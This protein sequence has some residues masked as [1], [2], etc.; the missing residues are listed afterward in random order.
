MIF[1][2]VC[3]ILSRCF[4]SWCWGVSIPH[5]YFKRW[6][7]LNS[8]R[9][10]KNCIIPSCDM[11]KCFSCLKKKKKSLLCLHH[12]NVV[13]LISH[14][15]ED[16]TV[17]HK[18]LKCTTCW[19]SWLFLTTLHKWQVSQGVKKKTDHKHNDTTSLTDIHVLYVNW[20]SKTFIITYVNMT[21]L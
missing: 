18:T 15:K 4:L 12:G 2:A 17:M 5:S 11:E 3:N 6:R 20:I 16:D 21:G 8:S 7:L 9:V 13:V 14:F 1:D 19:I 10:K